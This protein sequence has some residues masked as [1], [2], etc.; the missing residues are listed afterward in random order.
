MADLQSAYVSPEPVSPSMTYDD[1][2]S[3]LVPK[4]AQT[5]EYA[6][7]LARLTEA[8]PGLSETFRG[9]ILE[10]LDRNT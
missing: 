8:W 1:S 2:G 10:L 3:A 4:L 5:R 6:P 9:A 7:D